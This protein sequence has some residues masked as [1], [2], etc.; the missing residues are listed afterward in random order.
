MVKFDMHCHTKEGSLDGKVEIGVYIRRLQKQG[1]SGM[2]V[3]DHNSYDGY[4]HWKYELKHQKDFENFVVLKGIEYDTIDCGHILVLMPPDVKLRILELRGLPVKLL[5][6]FVHKYGGIL[7][8]A[9]PFGERYL[10]IV[11]TQMRKRRRKEQLDTLVQQFDFIEA[12]N[13]CETK[14]NN[15][16]ALNMAMHFHKPG[17]GGSDSHR[18]DCIGKAYTLVPDSVKNEADLI[19]Y[20]THTESTECGGTLYNGTT[21]KKIG[22]LNGVLVQGFYIYNFIG[23]WYRSISRHIELKH[24]KN[25]KY[26]DIKR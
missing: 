23:R 3:T 4:R 1:F 5:I 22:V 12:F 15:Q 21:K 24:L 11:P 14:E 17:F 2:L 6:Y 25:S 16:Q 26:I 7:G 13:A 10:S 19:E 9:H 8:P 20:V 18:L